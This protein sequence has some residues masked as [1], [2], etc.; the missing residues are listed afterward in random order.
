[1]FAVDGF[2]RI[3]LA[4]QAVKGDVRDKMIPGT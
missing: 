3:V 4:G 1:M 2:K